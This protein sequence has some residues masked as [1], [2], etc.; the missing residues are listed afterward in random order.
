M[1]HAFRHERAQ[2]HEEAWCQALIDRLLELPRFQEYW[3]RAEQSVPLPT[4]ARALIPLRLSAR[5]AGVLSFRLAS[6]PFTRDARFRII[7]YFPDDLRTM[8]YYA[9]RYSAT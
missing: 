6:E 9:L 2:F 4:A 7:Y 1:V 3:Q 8:Q 5:N